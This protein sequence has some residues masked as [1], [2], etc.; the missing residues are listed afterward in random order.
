VFGSELRDR[1]AKYAAIQ[2]AFGFE[3]GLLERPRIGRQTQVE[4]FRVTHIPS[5]AELKTSR[6]R[7]MDALG[8]F[9]AGRICPLGG[10]GSGTTVVTRSAIEL[11]RAACPDALERRLRL[12]PR[13]WEGERCG[14]RRAFG[15]SYES[16]P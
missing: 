7:G 8:Q 2:R 4:R 16:V 14:R 10:R 3:H 11:A 1:A 15:Q 5:A 12:L 13:R 6:G 9:M